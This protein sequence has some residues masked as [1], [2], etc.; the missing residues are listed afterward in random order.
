[1]FKA[2]AAPSDPPFVSADGLLAN[3][4]A[5]LNG[6]EAD[7]RNVFHRLDDVGSPGDR[8]VAEVHR[9]F[10]GVHG[11]AKAGHYR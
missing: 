9:R 5:Q 11:P 2:Q 8:G 1:M 10:G 6:F 7:G 3:I 4:L